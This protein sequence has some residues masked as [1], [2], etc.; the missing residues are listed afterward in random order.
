MF[1]FAISVLVLVSTSSLPAL[2]TWS[3]GLP[4]AARGMKPNGTKKCQ[5]VDHEV[6]ITRV[7]RCECRMFRLEDV[8]NQSVRNPH[9]ENMKNR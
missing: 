3:A 7:G 2:S 6:S 4:T 9:E 1:R 5:V 8:L